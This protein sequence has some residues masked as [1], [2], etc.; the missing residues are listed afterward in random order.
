MPFIRRAMPRI[1]PLVAVLFA[2]T[3]ASAQSGNAGAVRGTVTD[4]SG[5]VIPN[6]TVHLTN[7]ISGLDR[8]AT[9][10]PL[11]NSRFQTSRL[12]LM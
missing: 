8:T 12:P 5:A 1:L 6:A 3:S 11:A 10:T 7:E 9:T 2:A 4:P